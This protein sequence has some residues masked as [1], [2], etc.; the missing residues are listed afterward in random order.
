MTDYYDQQYSPNTIMCRCYSM[1]Y[2][3]PP[4]WTDDI[5]I[6][7]LTDNF[8][9]NFERNVKAKISH[10]T[11][12]FTCARHQLV[13][14]FCIWNL[15]CPWITAFDRPCQHATGCALVPAHCY[16]TLY[17]LHLHWAG[18]N[19]IVTSYYDGSVANVFT[20]LLVSSLKLYN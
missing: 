14:W 18:W 7:F 10:P 16:S 1:S 13:V 12:G 11:L 8:W 3:S 5:I 15:C 19:T 20:L 4:I 2:P 17:N 6:M 9:H